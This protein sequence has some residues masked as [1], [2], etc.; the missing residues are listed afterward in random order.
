MTVK[1]KVNVPMRLLFTISLAL[2]LAIGASAQT[3]LLDN[4]QV[5]DATS[6]KTVRLS[7]PSGITD[8]Q[9]LV[10]P[11]SAGTVGQVLTITAKSGN[12]LTLGWSTESVST[13]TASDRLTSDQDATAPAGLSVGVAANKKYQYSGVIVCNRKS[14]G[15]TTYSDNFIV[16]V[17]GPTNTS[18]VTLSVQCFDCPGSTTGVPTY[19]QAS[20]TSTSTA[21]INPAGAPPEYYTAVSL[22]VEGVVSTGSSSGNITIKVEQSGGDNNV[23]ISQ[24]SY[25]TVTGLD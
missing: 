16:T 8:N 5:Y 12:T 1:S 3:R 9:E 2:L 20:S 25:I 22:Y 7:K 15:G 21:A 19:V 23:V 10:F 13:I 18:K 14:T 24:N 11:S 6:N 17:T 4:I